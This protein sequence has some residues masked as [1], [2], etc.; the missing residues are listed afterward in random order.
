MKKK[1]I[2][3]CTNRAKR[4]DD[5]RKFFREKQEILKKQKAYLKTSDIRDPL[6]L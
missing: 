1:H 2:F 6:I 4:E 3:G 5:R